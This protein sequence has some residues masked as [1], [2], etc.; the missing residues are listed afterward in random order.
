MEAGLALGGDRKTLWATTAAGAGLIVFGLRS[1]EVP[2]RLDVAPMILVPDESA[3]GPFADRV[4]LLS[5]T[6]TGACR[7][8]DSYSRS[9]SPA[10]TDTAAGR[11]E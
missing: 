9:G 3:R 8:D 4:V 7:S 10:A 6:S 2:V 11:T 5:L 1:V